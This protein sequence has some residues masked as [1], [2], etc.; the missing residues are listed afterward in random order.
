MKKKKRKRET[1]NFKK[2]NR[3]KIRGR[4]VFVSL[5]VD[6]YMTIHDFL[7]LL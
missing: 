4:G 1:K 2:E 5:K 3:Q 7:V 6:E